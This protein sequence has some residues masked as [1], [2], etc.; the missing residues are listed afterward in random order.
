M[1]C[2]NKSESRLPNSYLELLKTGVQFL[3]TNKCQIFG[4]NK[5][6]WK[7]DLIE[8]GIQ[9]RNIVA[10]FSNS[11][12][13][14]QSLLTWPQWI[15]IVERC[16]STRYSFFYYKESLSIM[17]QYQPL[18]KI[19]TP[20]VLSPAFTVTVPTEFPDTV[21]KDIQIDRKDSIF[22]QNAI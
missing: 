4:T 2:Q 7:P 12:H 3:Q 13:I 20:L 18:S 19:Q 22:V 9:F 17:E 14:S 6:P 5:N 11:G 1:W 16:H 8:T 15:K 10:N 21:K